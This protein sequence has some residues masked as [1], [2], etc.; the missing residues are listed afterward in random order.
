MN[1][2]YIGSV[3]KRGV[4]SL[5]VCLFLDLRYNKALEIFLRNDY[6]YFKI[7]LCVSIVRSYLY[8][9]Q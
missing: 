9:N 6:S 8:A 5:F 7:L 3:I 2:E 4:F 1:I